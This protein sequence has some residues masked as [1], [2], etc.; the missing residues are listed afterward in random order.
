ML[1]HRLGSRMNLLDGYVS[2]DGTIGKRRTQVDTISPRLAISVRLLAESLGHRAG[3]YRYD[4]KSDVIEGRTVNVQPLWKVTWENYLRRRYATHHGDMS[5]TRVKSIAPGRTGVE[6]F[7]IEVAEDHSYVANGI[8]VKNCT[9]HTFAKN[10]QQ[11]ANNLTL[12]DPKKDAER[13]RATMWDVPR[14]AE[15]HHYRLIVVENVIEV[16]SWKPF[17]SWLGALA[18]LGYDHGFVYFNS[19]FAPPTPQ[20]R[21]RL[22]T[23]LWDRGCPAPNL[24]FRPQ[25]TCQYCEKPV[26]AVQ[27]WKTTFAEALAAAT[28]RNGGVR[29]EKIRYGNYGS[30]YDYRC[31]DCANEVIP[32]S[33]P[34]YSAVDWTLAGQRIGDSTLVPNTI[35][36]IRKGIERFGR[37]PLII[38]LDH[39]SDPGSKV[40]R[41]V[42]QPFPTQTGR[43]DRMLASAR[44]L[45]PFLQQLAMIPFIHE[46]RGGGSIG[47]SVTD[48]ASTVSADGNHHF[49]IEPSMIM[50]GR[51]NNVPRPVTEPTATATTAHGGAL[52]K[53]DGFY[54]KG[55]GDGTDPSMNHPFTDAFGTVTAQDH[56]GLVRLPLIDTFYGNGSG[57]RPVTDPVGSQTSKHRHAL[58]DPQAGVPD[59][60]DCFYRM[61]RPHE[62]KRVMAF[63]DGYRILGNDRDQVRQLGN[64]VTPPTAEMIVDRCVSAVFA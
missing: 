27:R 59:V 43:Q 8:V 57:A 64:A 2:A 38:P 31:P 11:S 52:F 14:F 26:G 32:Y 42:W 25:A 54:S 22:Y 4:Q 9:N 40:C 53:V 62:I 60:M 20:S 63:G 18:A 44:P 23:V 56:H 37:N 13:S 35:A 17:D 46:Q 30:Q 36:R 45:H 33:A 1:G 28:K 48:P 50:G 6:V 29:P 39:G 19:R 58:V 10:Q 12:W 34:A 5:W 15:Y 51:T 21:D 47:H 49:L 55:Y 16:R 7:N 41:P 61:L 3:L 24:D